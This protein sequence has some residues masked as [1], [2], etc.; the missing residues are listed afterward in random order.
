M[1][2]GCRERFDLD[3]YHYLATFNLIRRPRLLAL[4]AGCADRKDP[5]NVIAVGT[6][7]H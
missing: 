7:M 5:Q 6:R 1:P 4:L 2:A 3:F